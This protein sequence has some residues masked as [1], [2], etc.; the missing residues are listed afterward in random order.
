MHIQSL[1]ALGLFGLRA[2][3]L[4]SLSRRQTNEQIDEIMNLEPGFII[5]YGPER[6]MCTNNKT[7]K[8]WNDYEIL[9]RVS[10]FKS[11]PLG[12]IHSE[13]GYT[14]PSEIGTSSYTTKLDD[15]QVRRRDIS[16]WFC[17][18]CEYYVLRHAWDKLTTIQWGLRRPYIRGTVL[19]PSVCH[20]SFERDAQLRELHG[21]ASCRYWYRWPD[22]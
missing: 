12:C 19:M 18:H 4:P 7:P 17:H 15:H 3:A 6:E 21:Q 13:L 1:L 16:R 2:L 8:M 11:R 20:F 10:G 22:R 5:V 9:V 14:S